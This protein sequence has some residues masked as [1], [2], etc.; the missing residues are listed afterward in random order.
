MLGSAQNMSADVTVNLQARAPFR[1]QPLGVQPMRGH[2]QQMRLSR[3][4][5]TLLHLRPL[6]LSLALAQSQSACRPAQPGHDLVPPHPMLRLAPAPP[7]LH[8]TKHAT[9]RKLPTSANC[10]VV[11]VTTNVHN[12]QP[13][14]PTNAET[15]F[16]L[17][18][19]G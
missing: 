4:A 14:R 8:S 7:Q 19:P 1:C 9:I 10:Q 2:P 17:P 18:D 12:K 11:R 3:R 6:I 5:L 16:P 15:V 13:V